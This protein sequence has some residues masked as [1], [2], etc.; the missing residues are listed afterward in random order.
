M[1]TD[2]DSVPPSKQRT[3][4][5]PVAKKKKKKGTKRKIVRQLTEAEI[6][7][8][9]KQ[10]LTMLGVL[11]AMALTLWVFAHAG[12][13]YH[14]PRETRRQRDVT[15]AEL[16]REPKDAAIEFQHRL[17]TLN[18]KGAL[19]LSA[20]SLSED[21]KKAQ[22]ACDSNKTACAAKKK[23][24]AEAITSAVVLER[25]PMSAKIR[26]TTYRL[27]SGDQTFLALVER[28]PSGWKIT[29]H[30]ADAPGATLPAPSITPSQPIRIEAAPAG[31]AN[32]HAGLPAGSTNPHSLQA[33]P[34]GSAKP[35]VQP[36]PA[37]AG[38]ARP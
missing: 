15:T 13:N 10:T 24:V 21:V 18:Y 37:P 31:S 4:S 17:L 26:A 30:V 38:S 23:A 2:A 11:S 5:A 16:T 27:P 34:S 20:G 35:A 6:N 12:C 19:E 7:V 32:P 9:D 28:D 3:S 8:P 36:K 22:A 29:A 25:T 33:A 1:S 14:P